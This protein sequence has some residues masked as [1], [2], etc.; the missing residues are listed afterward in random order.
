[1]HSPPGMYIPKVH[2]YR[3]RIIESIV[4]HTLAEIEA[5]L[6]LLTVEILATQQL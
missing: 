2:A 4:A 6:C 3:L 1:M 5:Q